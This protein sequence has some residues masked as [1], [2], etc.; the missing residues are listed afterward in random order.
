MDD[1]S[2]FSSKIPS[3]ETIEEGRRGSLMVGLIVGGIVV[4]IGIIAYLIFGKYLVF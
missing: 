2:E 4:A 1:D 3:E